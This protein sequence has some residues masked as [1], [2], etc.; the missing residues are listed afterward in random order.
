MSRHHSHPIN[1]N[2]KIAEDSNEESDQS[3]HS[4]NTVPKGDDKTKVVA[5]G[6]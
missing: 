6:N 3:M 5:G 4:T 2:M 1:N